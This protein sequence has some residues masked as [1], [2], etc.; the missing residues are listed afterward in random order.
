MTPEPSWFGTK[1]DAG[2]SS[3]PLPLRLLRSVGLTPETRMRTRTSLG[4]GLGYGPLHPRSAARKRIEDFEA[5][6]DLAASTDF[7][8]GE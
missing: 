7:P 4:P 5:Q 8:A 1:V 2:V 3:E 6:R